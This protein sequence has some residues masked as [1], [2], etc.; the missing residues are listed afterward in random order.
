[1]Y[2]WRA[3]A[4]WYFARAQDDVNLCVLRMLEGT[5]SLDVAYITLISYIALAVQFF[6]TLGIQ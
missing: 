6:V 3:K 5:F 4:G 1:M 2:E